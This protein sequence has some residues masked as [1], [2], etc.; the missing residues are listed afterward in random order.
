MKSL[1]WIALILALIICV[2]GVFYVQKCFM[3]VLGTLLGRPSGLDAAGGRVDR[4]IESVSD[5][6]AAGRESLE[7]AGERIGDSQELA[8]R[9]GEGARA[10]EDRSAGLEAR[11][12]ELEASLGRIEDAAARGREAIRLGYAAVDR[13]EE[14]IRRLQAEGSE[15]GEAEKDLAD[16]GAD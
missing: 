7:R 1:K 10:I 16:G 14:V 15:A 12:R 5:S 13:L 3:P 4:D 8:E 2:A 6:L 9:A 11:N